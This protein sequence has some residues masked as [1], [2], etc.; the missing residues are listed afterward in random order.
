MRLEE[1]VS[2][3]VERVVPFLAPQAPLVVPRDARCFTEEIESLCDRQD[4]QEASPG[5]EASLI[6]ADVGEL[7]WSDLD[8]PSAFTATVASNQD[9]D[10][11]RDLLP[12]SRSFPLATLVTVKGH[13]VSRFKVHLGG[14]TFGRSED[15][16]VVLLQRTASRH[17]AEIRCEAGH[18][19]IRDLASSNG[20]YVNQ[21]RVTEAMLIHGDCVEVGDAV[22]EWVQPLPPV[23]ALEATQTQGEVTEAWDGE[24]LPDVVQ[25]APQ[26]SPV[27]PV[28]V[29][30]P[31]AAPD[32]PAPCAPRR[33]SS[34]P[35]TGRS[36]TRSPRSTPSPSPSGRSVGW[37]SCSRAP[38]RWPG[39]CASRPVWRWPSPPWRRVG[40]AT[41][42][43][44]SCFRRRSSSP[45]ATPPPM[46]AT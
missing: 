36:W 15:R 10:V 23:A 39:G 12:E 44:R 42:R 29:P 34:G 27:R 31:A 28:A 24:L 3:P 8:D 7:G 45:R 26:P 18:F 37:S 5:D 35:L 14:L 20:V 21:R 46:P 25:A 9:G 43:S 6:G 13:P 19:V 33:R 41:K 38:G 40:W 22:F 2:E 11:I 30:A 17:H 16:D 32:A 4:T 1:L